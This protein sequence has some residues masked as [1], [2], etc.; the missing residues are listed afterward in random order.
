[1]FLNQ[2][3]VI[4]K[5]Y[6]KVHLPSISHDESLALLSDGLLISTLVENE[7]GAIQMAMGSFF[8]ILLLSGVLWPLQV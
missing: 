8:P 1:M 4:V 5:L 3:L 2:N 7:V 6:E